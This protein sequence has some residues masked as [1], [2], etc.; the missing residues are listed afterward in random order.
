MEKLTKLNISYESKIRHDIVE[1]IEKILDGIKYQMSA[2]SK[3]NNDSNLVENT[4]EIFTDKPEVLIE[5][6]KDKVPHIDGSY[7]INKD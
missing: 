6:L 3:I 4:I 5:N 1:K 7:E 2:S